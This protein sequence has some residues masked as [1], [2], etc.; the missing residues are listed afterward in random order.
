MLIK[1]LVLKEIEFKFVFKFVL[2]KI[3]IENGICN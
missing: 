1:L 2:L 3:L